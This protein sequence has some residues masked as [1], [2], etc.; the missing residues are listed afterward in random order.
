MNKLR[1]APLLL[2]AAI[3]LMNPGGLFSEPSACCWQFDRHCEGACE[4]HGGMMVTNCCGL[5][6]GENCFCYDGYVDEHPG[7]TYCDPCIE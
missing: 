2:I 7:G 4:A 5:Y 1:L 6:G 3:S